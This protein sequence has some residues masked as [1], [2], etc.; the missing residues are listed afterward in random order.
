M[1]LNP[2]AHHDPSTNGAPQVIAVMFFALIPLTAFLPFAEVT[3]QGSTYPRLLIQIVRTDSGFNP[4]ALLLLLAPLIGVA[5]GLIARS[6]W[7]GASALISLLALVMIGLT[8]FMLVPQ[9]RGLAGGTGSVYMG[10]GSYALIVGYS[11]IMLVTGAA[12]FLTRER[13]RKFRKSIA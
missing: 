6:I 7:R 9:M 10:I 11:V 5:D 13:P 12:A 4:F 8:F 1:R 3:F 2:F